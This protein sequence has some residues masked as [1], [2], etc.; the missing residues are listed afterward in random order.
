[1][2]SANG[3]F[4]KG[5]DAMTPEELDRRFEKTINDIQGSEFGKLMVYAGQDA[6]SLI[7]RR[8]QEEGTNAEGQKYTPYSVKPMLA[9]C[10]SMTTNACGRIAGSKQKRR[11]LKWVT[12][13]RG[14]KN[15]RLF[16]LPGGYKQYRDIHGRQTGYVD[17]T[18]TG[19]MWGN[20]KIVSDNSEHNGGIVRIGA[21]TELDKKK[22][23]GNTARRGPI[24]K[25][26]QSELSYLS[27]R[28]NMGITQIFHNNGL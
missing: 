2:S 4:T 27:G 10:S 6:L 25:L 7:R 20:V 18:F 13:H 28:F 3:I 24:L 14:G 15:I 17:F 8:V 5:S 9:N 12:L 1:M 19:K 11:E 26:S 21:T 23:E 22:L 16:E